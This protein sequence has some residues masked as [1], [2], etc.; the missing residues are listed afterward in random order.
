MEEPE[1]FTETEFKKN[2]QTQANCSMAEAVK[3]D[4][5]EIMIEKF[6]KDQKSKN[7]IKQ[8]VT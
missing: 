5:D 6:L 3:I 1:G 4:E 2:E 8:E 7:S